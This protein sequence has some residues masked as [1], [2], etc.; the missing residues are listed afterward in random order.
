MRD[1]SQTT[2]FVLMVM[3]RPTAV[4]LDEDKAD[5]AVEKEALERGCLAGGDLLHYIEVPLYNGATD[6]E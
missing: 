3:E 2:V 6:D 1:E 4:Y 5:A